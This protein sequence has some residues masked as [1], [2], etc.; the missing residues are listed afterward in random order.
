[1]RDEM[2]REENRSIRYSVL[3]CSLPDGSSAHVGLW[4]M[5]GCYL[6]PEILINIHVAGLFTLQCKLYWYTIV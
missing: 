3:W 5:D 1:M 2:R 6:V 4:S